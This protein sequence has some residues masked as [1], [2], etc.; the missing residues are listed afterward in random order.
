MTIKKRVAEFIVKN[1]LESL[2]TGEILDRL[3]ENPKNRQYKK[4]TLRRS[5]QKTLKNLRS[6][7]LR[8][9]GMTPD[10]KTGHNYTYHKDSDTY[11][12]QTKNQVFKSI[13]AKEVQSWVQWY[14]QDG[15]RMTQSEIAREAYRKHRRPLT[16]KQIAAIFKALGIQ[17]SSLPLAP[18]Q[19]DSDPLAGIE[20]TVR[21]A[22]EAAIETRLAARDA[23][24][25]R[26]QYE[27]LLRA[28]RETIHMIGERIVSAVESSEFNPDDIDPVTF[29]RNLTPYELVIFLSD[30]HIGQAFDCPFGAFN[31]DIARERVHELARECQDWLTAYKRPLQHLHIA[32]GGDMVDGVLPMRK[33]H[34]LSQDL[35]EG[36][37][38][39]VASELLAWFIEGLANRS[40][41]PTSVHSV[42]GNHDRAGG[43][44]ENDPNRIIGQWL[45]QLTEARIRNPQV[46]WKHAEETYNTWD[47][48][49][50]RIVLSHGDQVPRDPRRLAHPFR[51]HK[52][53]NYLILT[54]H[55]HNPVT[56]EDLDVMWV[57]NGALPGPDPYA[58]TRIGVGARPVQMMIEV[59]ASGPRPAVSIPLR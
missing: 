23:S 48:F 52:V 37:Q 18:H 44:R 40:G 32:V 36:E 20:S 47:C 11:T 46:V 15:G 57:Q 8:E 29:N 50:T 24:Y 17:K 3:L 14:S 41:C 25:W 1:G 53:N 12:I 58:A 13:P 51:D 45:A 4:T 16:R 27:K 56:Q 21:E 6:V 43:V 26:K 9:A 5:I 38:V 39:N 49:N 2:E 33:Q 19:I 35:H 42:S 30:W 22:Q 54:G 7:D 59:R 55:K 10:Q 34:S 31:K 28:R